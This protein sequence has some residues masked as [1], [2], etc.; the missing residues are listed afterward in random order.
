MVAGRVGGDSSGRPGRSQVNGQGGPVDLRLALATARYATQAGGA[1]I[2]SAGVGFHQ[3][4]SKGRGDYVTE[5]DPRSEAVVVRILPAAF[6]QLPVLAEEGG[7][8]ESSIGWVVDALDGTTNFS[9]GF[10][11]V[12]LSVALLVDGR[13]AVGTVHA[14]FLGWTYSA[15][16]GE[17]AFDERGRRLRMGDPEPSRAVVSTGFPIKTPE[18]LPRQ[19][20]TLARVLDIVEDGRGTGAASLDLAFTAAGVFDGYFELGLKVWDIAA[21]VLLVTEAGGLVSD[22]EGGQTQLKTGDIVAGAPRVHRAILEATR[23]GS[24]AD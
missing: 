10:P 12:G 16:L 19:I 17:G 9:R 1:L 23:S 14:P 13:P 4:K 24:G 5:V 15:R 6:P 8:E 7:G 11:L 22:W 18:R 2:R 3:T 20:G 21:G